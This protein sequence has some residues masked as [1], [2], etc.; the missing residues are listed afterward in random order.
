VRAEQRA[1]CATRFE[2]TPLNQMIVAIYR[3]SVRR[4]GVSW[5]AEDAQSPPAGLIQNA[6]AN[7]P[8]KRVAVHDDVVVVLKDAATINVNRDSG[9]AGRPAVNAVKNP[10]DQ[11][12]ADEDLVGAR[13]VDAGVDSAV[14]TADRQVA[15]GDV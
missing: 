3:F 15:D 9:R 8:V 6:I 13:S 11:N 14:K 2:A 5:R 12:V 1:P 7:A 4:K 10:R